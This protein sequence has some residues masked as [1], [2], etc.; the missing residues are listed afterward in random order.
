MSNLPSPVK[1]EKSHSNALLVLVLLTAIF[2]AM[3]YMV[4]VI[5]VPCGANGHWTIW[6]MFKGTC[7]FPVP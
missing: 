7:D 3:Y 2:A 5:T 4:F 6:Q 1:I